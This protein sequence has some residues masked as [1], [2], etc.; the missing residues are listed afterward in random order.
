MFG[1]AAWT[2]V[3]YLLTYL[4]VEGGIKKVREDIL[5]EEIIKLCETFLNSGGPHSY[6]SYSEILKLKRTY[7]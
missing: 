7:F 3:S 1:V 6:M 5:K 2:W 4:S